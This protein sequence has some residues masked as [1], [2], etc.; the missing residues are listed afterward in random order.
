MLVLTS[1]SLKVETFTEELVQYGM[2]CRVIRTLPYAYS[3]CKDFIAN[4]INLVDLSENNNNKM[5]YIQANDL[6][7][8]F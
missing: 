6:Y 1:E 2:R 4:Y 3:P 7:P 5:R 8:K